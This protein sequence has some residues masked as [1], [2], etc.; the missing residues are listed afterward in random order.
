ML[1]EKLAACLAVSRHGLSTAELTALLDPGDPHGHV[2][3]LLR[4]LR[5]YLMRRGELLDFFH[6]QTREAAAEAYVHEADNE[7]GVATARKAHQA[8]AECLRSFADP[9]RNGSFFGGRARAMEEMPYHLHHA[10]EP[11]ALH[12]L[13]GDVAYLDAALRAGLAYA[14]LR[15][16]GAALAAWP[17]A[18]AEAVRRAVAGSM[19]TQIVYPGFGLSAMTNRLAWETG[20]SSGVPDIVA[21]A[22]E[23][24]DAAGPWL[25]TASMLPGKGDAAFGASRSLQCSCGT[26]GVIV[27]GESDGAVEVH[28][29]LSGAVLAQ[30]T[31]A[32]RNALGLAA[33]PTHQTV[34]WAEKS[35]AIHTE[36]S[37]HV[38]A[39][40]A[41]EEALAYP[42][43]DCVIAVRRDGALVAWNPLTG[44]VSVLLPSVPAPPA[45]VAGRGTV[46]CA[47]FPSR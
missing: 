27:T 24:L 4:L 6:Q 1:V 45:H 15:D 26:D 47:V 20:D 35:G 39:G 28:S 19:R 9:E 3:A 14:Y 21:I 17:C 42:H 16:A 25:E 37:Q 36:T 11:C 5:P 31:I 13:L 23:R 41:R 18:G 32:C 7:A 33:E 22:R 30:R 2:A 10:G 46:R 40:R 12:S 34:A 43:P 29:V 44:D 8:L 38:L